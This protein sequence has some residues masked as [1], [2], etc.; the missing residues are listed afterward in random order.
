MNEN[1]SSTFDLGRQVGIWVGIRGVGR[2]GEG[3]G[4]DEGVGG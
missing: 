1:K 4:G 2:G 3:G